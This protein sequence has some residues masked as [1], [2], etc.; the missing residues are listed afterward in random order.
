MCTFFPPLLRRLVATGALCLASALALYAQPAA[1][2]PGPD[3]NRPFT[4]GLH[5]H[6]LLYSSRTGSGIDKDI[7]DALAQ[8]SGCNITT[9]VLP[10]ARI[11][12]LIETGAL[13]FS[14]S[15]IA[16]PERDR[17]ASF[18]WYFSNRYYLLVRQDA[19]VEKL[20]DFDSNT[21]LQLGV[22]RSFRYGARA[23]QWVD[24]LTAAGRVSHASGLEP[25]YQ[26]LLLGRIHGMIIEPFDMMDVEGTEVKSVTRV[27][28]LDDPAIPHGLIMSKKS[29][30]PAEQA[31]WRALVDGLRQDGTVLRIFEKYFPPELARAM[32]NF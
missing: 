24:Q 13:D 3:C 26:V 2:G 25:L 20:S 18:A 30:P 28:A 8:R 14:L 12:Q 15:G 5:V 11:W 4:L 22:I 7:T 27:L 21:A 1:A 32:V 19:G 17:F 6:G 10:R 9:T 31:K 16:T 23:N 29:L